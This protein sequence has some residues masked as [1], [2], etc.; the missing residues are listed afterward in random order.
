LRLK[1]GST[2]WD[3]ETIE[4]IHDGEKGDSL[5][6]LSLDN[7]YDSVA[8][9]SAS[10]E[11]FSA[12]PITTTAKAYLGKDEIISGYNITCTPSFTKD[13]TI[14]FAGTVTGGSVP[15]LSGV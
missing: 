14:R 9:N 7:D 10:G 15:T 2:I 1:R 12:L 8:I 13:I 6:K 4:F 3:E 11:I 5:Y